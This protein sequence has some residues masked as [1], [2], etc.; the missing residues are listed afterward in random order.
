MNV[1]TVSSLFALTCLS[2]SDRNFSLTRKLPSSGAAVVVS[3][4]APGVASEAA[5]EA[6]KFPVSVSGVSSV[7]VDIRHMNINAYGQF[8]ANCILRFLFT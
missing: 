6:E 1:C 3:G 4:M 7:C 5:P 8:W 2:T